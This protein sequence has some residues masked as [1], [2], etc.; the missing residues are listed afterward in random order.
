MDFLKNI[1]T[2]L[3]NEYKSNPVVIGGMFMMTKG[4]AN[5]HIMPRYS[6]TPLLCKED[7]DNWLRFIEMPSPLVVVGYLASHDPGLKLRMEH[8]H[9]F[10]NHGDGGHFHY[11]TTP[12][13][14]EF[15]AYFNVAATL[16]RVDRWDDSHHTVDYAD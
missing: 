9:C 6:A 11:E 7:V 13:E 12:E 8:F 1:T 16:Y 3:K 5:I 15:V 10:S 2:A 14:V 4:K